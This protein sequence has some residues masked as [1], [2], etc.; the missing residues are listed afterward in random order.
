M[1][2]DAVD[3]P[4]SQPSFNGGSINAAIEFLNVPPGV[5]TSA[6]VDGKIFKD[7]QISK[8]KQSGVY[9]QPFVS[10]D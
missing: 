6:D 3:K 9:R 8:T 4:H 10:I 2:W 7:L 1:S 5:K